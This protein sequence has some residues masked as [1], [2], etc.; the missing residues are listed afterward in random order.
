VLADHDPAAQ[1]VVMREVD[2]RLRHQ[3]QVSL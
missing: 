2:A 1:A 3:W